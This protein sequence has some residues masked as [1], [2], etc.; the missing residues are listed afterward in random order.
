VA[1][2]VLL[3]KEQR[4]FVQSIDHV[5]PFNDLDVNCPKNPFGLAQ[6]YFW[7]LDVLKMPTE[8]RP[9]PVERIVDEMV[10]EIRVCSL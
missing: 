5:S 1:L 3:E 4:V 6:N 2:E 8:I 10:K 7:N 9:C